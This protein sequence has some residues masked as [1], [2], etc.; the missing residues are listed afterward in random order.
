MPG[1]M[2]I[3]GVAVFFA[4][5]PQYFDSS[6]KLL[7]NWMSQASQT[8]TIGSEKGNTNNRHNLGRMA[9]A[10]DTMG[11]NYGFNYSGAPWTGMMAMVWFTVIV[12]PAIHNLL[13]LFSC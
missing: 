12:A 5:F 10:S 2:T 11:H 6:L 3:L 4:I 9:L 7:S 13:A 1:T 8:V